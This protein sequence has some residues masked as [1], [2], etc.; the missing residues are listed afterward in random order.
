MK[1]SSYAWSH[2]SPIRSRSALAWLA[3]GVARQLSTES[4]TPSRSVSGG[5]GKLDD[6]LYRMLPRS[7]PVELSHHCSKSAA[8]RTTEPSTATT[9]SLM[10][11]RPV[12][13]LQPRPDPET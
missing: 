5:G 13:L 12:R 6:A 1:V 7:L 10:S 3:L 2:A 9:T 8:K 4:G 11:N